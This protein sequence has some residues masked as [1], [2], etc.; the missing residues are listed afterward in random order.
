[1]DTPSFK[2]DSIAHD[3]SITNAGKLGLYVFNKSKNA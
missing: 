3:T 2:E 1:M